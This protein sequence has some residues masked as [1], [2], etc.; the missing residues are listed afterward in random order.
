MVNLARWSL[1][2]RKCI[3][4]RASTSKPSRRLHLPSVQLPAFPSAPDPTA[5]DMSARDSK[6][7]VTRVKWDQLMDSLSRDHANPSRV[8]SAYLELGRVMGFE[9]VPLHVQQQVLRKSVPDTQ[10]LR[11]SLARRMQ[12]GNRPS[13]PHIYESRLQTVVAHIRESGRKPELE[14]YNFILEQFAAVGHQTGARMVFQELTQVIGVQPS[15]KTYGLCLQAIAHR[16]TLP[17]PYRYQRIMLVEASR[18]CTEL[19]DDMWDRRIPLTSVNFDLVHRIFKET[20]DRS[21]F[22]KLLR[23]GYGIDLAYPDRPLLEI[24][25]PG[26]LTGVA[27]IDS[28]KGFTPLPFSTAALNTL[29]DMLGRTK[30]VSRMVMA[31]E[32]LTSPLPTLSNSSPAQW[33]DDEDDDPTFFQFTSSDGGPRPHEFPSAVPN[34]TTFSLLI[35]YASKAKHAVF[36]R[37]YVVQAMIRDREVD[38]QLR[39]DLSSKPLEEIP[40]PNFAVNRGTFLPPYGMANRT[41]HFAFLRW[42]YGQTR[43]ALQRKKDDLA[44]YI[45]WQQ[46]HIIPPNQEEE[47]DTVDS[48][49]PSLPVSPTPA[50]PELSEALLV[51][52]D[53]PPPSPKPTHKP[54]DIGRHI[55]LLERDVQELGDLV[56]HIQTGVR[57]LSQRVKERLGRRIW[58]GKNIFL[59]SQNARVYVSRRDW[60]KRVGFVTP[61]RK[62]TLVPSHADSHQAHYGSREPAPHT[63]TEQQRR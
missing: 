51:D 24:Q 58:Q 6:S 54:I 7:F 33:I 18:M 19:L 29:I 46:K 61:R 10:K 26:I 39:A 63:N 44:F 14:D 47:P 48:S 28:F 22:E 55:W 37:H 9:N 17:C 56:R 35:R 53:A 25:G 1:G 50:M 2:I 60:M 3:K 41:K 20:S 16:L 11:Y 12:A 5:L 62:P 42:C 36:A 32:V 31:Y 30:Q 57:R 8:W 23:V 59:M 4:S 45:A 34:T 21:T 43:V 15:F 49:N 13:T 27:D 38:A 40:S 52:L